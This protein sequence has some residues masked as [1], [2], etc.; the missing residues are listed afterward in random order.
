M[1]VI[2]SMISETNC[3]LEFHNVYVINSV[4]FRVLRVSVVFLSFLLLLNSYKVLN[5]FI[6]FDQG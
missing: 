1:F 2:Y 4:F 3:N 5:N 6:Y